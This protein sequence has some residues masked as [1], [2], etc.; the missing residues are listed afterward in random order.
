MIWPTRIFR[1]KNFEDENFRTFNNDI[2]GKSSVRGNFSWAEMGVKRVLDKFRSQKTFRKIY[3]GCVDNLFLWTWSTNMTLESNCHILI[4]QRLLKLS[5]R[6]RY[7]R[8]Q[9]TTFEGLEPLIW[10]PEICYLEK[11]FFFFSMVRFCVQVFK[12]EIL[13]RNVSNIQK[14]LVFNRQFPTHTKPVFH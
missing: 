11:T 4:I 10:N 9:L 6:A 7:R 5:E 8:Q 1:R 14:I 2:F 3:C 12:T 13:L